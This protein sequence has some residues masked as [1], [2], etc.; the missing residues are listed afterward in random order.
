MAHFAPD[1]AIFAT[2]PNANMHD[3]FVGPMVLWLQAMNTLNAMDNKVAVVTG[4]TQGIGEAVCHLF[5]DR[6][7]R[8]LVVTGRDQARGENVVRALKDKGADAIFVEANLENIDHCRNIISEADR[9]FGQVDALVNAAGLTDRGTIL[10]T[11]PELFDRLFAVN[12]KA[13]FFLTQDAA[14]I[15]RRQGTPG[16]VVN[17]ISM[18]SHGGQPFICAYSG[19]KGAMVTLTRN[20]AF[21][22]M[23]DHIRVNGLNIGWT[24]T[25]GE[26][27]VQK[28]FHDADED[29]LKHAQA[30]QPFGRLIKTDEVAR[31]V[32][33]L[34]SDESGLI[35]GSII[36]FDQSVTGSWESAP[37][38]T[39]LA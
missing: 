7:C 17:I 22:L 38:P 32:G 37:H 36:D 14:K 1:S 13:P 33:Y 16:T 6:G 28:T 5:A 30:D 29:W 21:S 24:D 26:H 11:S 2:E 9:H 20:I 18:S 19:S 12:T 4:S 8:A 3:L 39:R 34:S 35:T 25:P 15:M 31:A 23:R 27:R 10:D